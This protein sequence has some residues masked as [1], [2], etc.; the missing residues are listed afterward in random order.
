MAVEKA[1]VQ[2][3]ENPVLGTQFAMDSAHILRVP[4]IV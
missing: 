1:Q 4:A 2:S 3:T